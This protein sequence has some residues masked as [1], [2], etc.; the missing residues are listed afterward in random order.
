METQFFYKGPLSCYTLNK[1]YIVPQNIVEYIFANKI[2]ICRLPKK[3]R[4]WD[5]EWVWLYP[6]F[7]PKIYFKTKHLEELENLYGKENVKGKKFYI[8]VGREVPF[9]SKKTK[10]CYFFTSPNYMKPFYNRS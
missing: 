4:F 6:E 8:M 10:H 1:N 7:G 2:M 5:M 3:Q 9:C